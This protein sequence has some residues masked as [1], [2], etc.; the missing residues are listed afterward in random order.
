MKSYLLNERVQPPKS[1]F[2]GGPQEAPAPWTP[3][4][5]RW[6]G[7]VQMSCVMCRHRVRKPCRNLHCS[8]KEA[9]AR[10]TRLMLVP[11]RLVLAPLERW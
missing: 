1:P 6:S 7:R 4:C 3:E 8:R 5:C 9:P 10:L 11:S 2:K